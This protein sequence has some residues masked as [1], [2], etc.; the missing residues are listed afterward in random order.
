MC[1]TWGSRILSERVL[2]F[3]IG[4]AVGAPLN[5]V[6]LAEAEKSPP[7]STPFE[8]FAVDGVECCWGVRSIVAADFFDGSVIT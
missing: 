7:L 5:G 3:S 1:T 2:L 4:P 8:C 6:G